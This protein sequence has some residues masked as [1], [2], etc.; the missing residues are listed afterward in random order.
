MMAI[1]LW[2]DPLGL[3]DI[4][5]PVLLSGSHG[6]MAWLTFGQPQ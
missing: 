1:D 2:L 6:G 4:C 5:E 3:Y